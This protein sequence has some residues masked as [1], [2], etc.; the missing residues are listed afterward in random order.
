MI[1]RGPLN[2]QPETPAR[3]REIVSWAMYDFANSAF[4]TLIVTFIFSKYFAERIAP[5]PLQGAI[6]WT[7]AVQVSALAVAFVMPVLGAMA[8][9]GG[10]KKHFLF[11]ATLACVGL[12]ASL[13]WMRPGDAWLAAAL[14]IFANVAYE[15]TQSLYNAFLPEIST[16]ENIGRVSGLGWGLGYFGGLIGLALALGMV[17]GWLPEEG[18]VH[19]RATNLLA[20]GWFLVFSIP[21]FLFLRERQARRSAPLGEHVR[22][23]FARV[24]Q[25]AGHLREYREAAKLLLA[26]LVYNDGLVTVF[27]MAAIYAGAVFGM[28]TSEVLVMGIV[29][30]V[31]AGGS[32]IAFGFVNDHIGGKRT[33]AITLVVLLATTLLAFV[34]RDRTWFWAAAILLGLMVG[35]NQAASRALLGSFIPKSKQGE[36]FGFYAFSGKLASVLGPLSYG[37]VLGA[38]ESHR[39]ALASIA[40]FFVVGLALLAWVDETEGKALAREMS[41]AL[42]GGA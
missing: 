34:A 23:G 25:T 30:N 33:I 20:A 9:Y 15:I 6:W 19:V 29:V 31:A 36:L 12:T 24:R 38:T 35:P 32:A 42:E 7:R 28:D 10:R 4:T 13:F 22:R 11:V 5:D 37:V 18:D 16:S 2:A 8:D 41:R 40:V 14:F 3:R 27:A 21:T 1:G 39:W 17:T 26:R